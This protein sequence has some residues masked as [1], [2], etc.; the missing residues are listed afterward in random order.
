MQKIHVQLDKRIDNS[1]DILVEQ[2]LF[3]RIPVLLK[4]N[5]W[6][7]KYAIITDSAVAGLYGK[8]LHADLHKNGLKSRLIVIPKGEKTKN[9][10]TCEKVLTTLSAKGFSRQD[11]IIAL[12]GGMTGDTAG[13]TAA[14]FMRGINLIHIPTTLIAAVD[15]SIGG[16]TGVNL[17]TGKNLAGAFHQ[18]KAVLIDPSII[19]ALPKNL[20]LDGMAEVIKYSI[21]AD[22]K[23]FDFLS[24]IFSK[25]RRPS[26]PQLQKIIIESCRIKAGIVSRDEKEGG[27]RKVLNYGHTIGH[28]IEQLSRYRLS[29]GESITHGMIIVNNICVQKG[30]LRAVE[31]N[32]MNTL[33]KNA[34][35]VKKQFSFRPDKV[36]DV[37]KRDKKV[38]NGKIIFVIPKKIG[39][40][41]FTGEITKQD[42]VKAYKQYVS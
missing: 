10:G 4:K 7:A 18:P 42:F 36:W 29:H 35:I 23:F 33:L 34:G 1:Y 15:S 31:R 37:M 30:L 9:L 38:V 27:I 25:K 11:A 39:K 12:G 20:I 5:S 6:G 2:G 32:K 28:A 3:K 19:N 21:L 17:P 24:K 22:E 8:R 41:E 14:L 40:T 13:L 16:K 26:L